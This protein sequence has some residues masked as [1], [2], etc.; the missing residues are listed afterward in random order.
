MNIFEQKIRLWRAALIYEASSWSVRKFREGLAEIFQAEQER[1]F[2][3]LPVFLGAGIAI[4]F[5]LPNEPSWNVALLIVL[6]PLVILLAL[7]LISGFDH[8]AIVFV[9]ALVMFGVGFFLSKTRTEIVSAPVITQ[10]LDGAIMKG[11]IVS[12][13]PAPQKK[14]QR[15]VVEPVAISRLAL[16]ELPRKVRVKIK[17][18]DGREHFRAGDRIAVKVLLF[19]PPGPVLPGGYDFARALWFDRIGGT[20]VALDLPQKLPHGILKEGLWSR[21]GAFLDNGRNA[22]AERI[23]A[24]AEGKASRD[25]R[26]IAVALIVGKRG[27]IPD[28]IR[29]MLRDTGLAHILAISGLHMAALAG[30]IYF[31]VRALLAFFPALALR[32]PIKKW[33]IVPALIGSVIYLML[34]GGSVATQRAFIMFAVA[35][36]AIFAGAQVVTMR[37]VVLAA[38]VILTLTPESLFHA[39]FQLSFAA[40]MAIIAV[41]ELVSLRGLHRSAFD[42]AYV[43]LWRRMSRA[44]LTLALTS[45]AAWSATGPLAVIHFNRIAVAPALIANL[46]VLPLFTLW[47]M[48]SIVVA[49]GLMPFGL[50]GPILVFLTWGI[51][52]IIAIVRFITEYIGAAQLVASPPASV[53]ILYVVGGLWLFFWRTTWRW[54][55]LVPLVFAAGQGF[56]F[57]AE[58]YDLL[59]SREGSMIALRDVDGRLYPSSR[60]GLWT[61]EQWLRADGDQ[62]NPW[63][64]YDRRKFSCTKVGCISAMENRPKVLLLRD[65]ESQQ[66]RFLCEGIDIVIF[67]REA[68][69]DLCSSARLRITHA[70]IMRDGV[71]GVFF[72]QDGF[73]VHKTEPR[74]GVRFWTGSNIP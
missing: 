60:T 21:L 70:D 52:S 13:D 4:Y 68:P 71:H 31:L 18:F 65:P 56:L 22:I 26:G 74:R 46:S 47:I 62:R 63:R 57:K 19:P 61:L 44:V 59:V 38:L 30:T 24:G 17:P 51:E 6:A 29:D 50:D 66:A 45:L 42:G 40:T 28:R 11:R 16:D 58:R 27:F 49:L 37:N 15:W 64:V 5:V 73:E 55:G 23:M 36:L 54:L 8:I 67:M 20:S 34:A 7:G 2:L 39:G 9:M 10:K 35:G 33:A 53:F 32:Y 48:P 25:A 1:W 41:Y 43:L 72:R 3:F 69:D 14:P 12:I